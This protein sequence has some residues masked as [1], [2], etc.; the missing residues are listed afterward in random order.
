MMRHIFVQKQAPE[1]E[2]ALGT[3]QLSI[4]GHFREEPSHA[5][6]RPS[7]VEEAILL[8]CT[9]G[10]GTLFCQ[11]KDWSIGAGDMF[12]LDQ[13][14]P[15][16]YASSEQF[17]W[18]IY[19]CHF[20]GDF[21]PLY[22]L[23]AERGMTPV[24]HP[25]VAAEILK[26]FEEIL[27]LAEGRLT[28][29]LRAGELSR[30]VL[31]ELLDS[32]SPRQDGLI[33]RVE[34]YL[35]ETLSQPV[36]LAQ[37]EQQFHLSRYHLARRFRQETGYPPMEYRMRLRIAAACRLLLETDC[38]ILE[39]SR[40]LGYNTP[41]YFSEQFKQATGCSPALFRRTMKRTSREKTQKNPGNEKSAG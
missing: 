33:P 23:F 11:G 40:E 18:D 8:Y 28:D 21:A 20:S 38:T 19:W 26:Q 1:L 35:K 3:V 30:M 25:G 15:H 14:E 7:G 31:L 37:L 12:L 24:F 10:Q 34:A 5:I 13:R 32:S 36:D 17:P 27:R 6:T 2:K 16:G 29:Q 41:Y 39:I 9:G 22:R 4:C